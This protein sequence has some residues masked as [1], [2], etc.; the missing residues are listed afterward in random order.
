MSQ[1]F[2]TDGSPSREADD[3][4]GRPHALDLLVAQKKRNAELELGLR[5]VRD[6]IEEDLRLGAETSQATQRLM[7]SDIG[8]ALKIES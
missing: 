8:R 2:Y 5:L 7:L 6:Q 1:V 4:D 3:D